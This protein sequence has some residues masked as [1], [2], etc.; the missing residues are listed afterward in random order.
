[1][2]NLNNKIITWVDSFDVPLNINNQIFLV[3]GNDTH[4]K[5][6]EHENSLRAKQLSIEK[7]LEL[8]K[9]L[10]NLK[11]T[12]DFFKE[13]EEEQIDQ[14]VQM[15]IVRLFLEA[16][17]GK[18]SPKKTT[19]VQCLIA[20][21]K[22]VSEKMYYSIEN[23]SHT[24]WD[25]IYSNFISFFEKKSFYLNEENGRI[26][27]FIEF[28]RVYNFSFYEI[29]KYTRLSYEKINKISSSVSTR[30]NIEHY[31]VVLLEDY[32]KSQKN[33]MVEKQQEILRLENELKKLKDDKSTNKVEENIVVAS[34]GFVV[35]IMVDDKETIKFIE[36]PIAI[37]GKTV[38]TIYD[39]F[40]EDY[41]YLWFSSDNKKIKRNSLIDTQL[42]QQINNR[43]EFNKQSDYHSER[44][45]YLH[46]S[47]PAVLKKMIEKLKKAIQGELLKVHAVFLD[48]HSSRY[49]CDRCQEASQ[50]MQNQ[51]GPFLKIL[52]NLIKKEFKRENHI[53][54]NNKLKLI[55]RASADIEFGNDRNPKNS[56]NPHYVFNFE[57]DQ[58]NY[59]FLMDTNK[60]ALENKKIPDKLCNKFK[61]GVHKYTFFS[62]SENDNPTKNLILAYNDI[63]AKTKI[64]AAC[65]IQ[66]FWRNRP[67]RISDVE[68]RFEKI[69]NHFSVQNPTINVEEQVV[70]VKLTIEN[71]G[72]PLQEI[73]RAINDMIPQDGGFK[74]KVE[75]GGL[76]F[77]FFKDKFLK[78]IGV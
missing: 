9:N 3:S 2:Q 6:K 8:E 46:L 41:N 22:H 25:Y 37:Q 72:W 26:K 57:Q 56:L 4:A 40:N 71:N 11:N 49:L 75:E 78:Y 15:G 36:I 19:L 30:I 73:A 51:D 59:I 74:V 50:T 66:A 42:K 20:N 61:Y 60:I 77:E 39:H 5:L 47:D 35:S 10:F 21:I 16:Y 48:F 65:V 13:K 12:V 70:I 53:V 45:L 64:E 54:P 28:L 34:V 67:I 18:S 52:T 17:S 76:K 38:Q 44:T 29:L 55:I 32:E 63:T 58:T 27:N 1:M 43:W 14:R 23:T 7:I 24:W 68:K 31:L 69:C 33:Y 62:S